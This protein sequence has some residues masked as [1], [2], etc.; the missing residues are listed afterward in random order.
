MH[1]F[2]CLEFKRSQKSSCRSERHGGGNDEIFNEITHYIDASNVYG[3]TA[4]IL[5]SLKHGTQGRLKGH[6]QG[7][8]FLLPDEDDIEAVVEEETCELPRSLE[9]APNFAAGDTRSNENPGLQSMHTVW[10]REHNRLARQIKALTPHKHDEEIMLEARRYVIAQMQNVVYNEFLA[11]V[12][13]E[14]TLE[15]YNLKVDAVS[16]YD[17]NVEATIFAEFSTA[18]FRFGHSLISSLIEFYKEVGQTLVKQQEALD[19]NFF[20]T[21]LVR[22]DQQ[23]GLIFKGNITRFLIFRP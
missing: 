6:H 10:A 9:D 22:Q 11:E 2:R 14:A 18:T 3:S 15:R 5:N 16:Q 13:S 4:K 17:E 1:Y 20:N 12:L 21:T 23:L 19:D 7:K 8:S